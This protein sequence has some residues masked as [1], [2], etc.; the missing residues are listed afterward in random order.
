MP[1]DEDSVLIEKRYLARG[2]GMLLVG[3]TGIGKSSLACQIAY[4]F[5]LGIPC[6]GLQPKVEMRTL[7]MQAEND[8][9]DFVEMREGVPAR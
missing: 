4:S 8:D 6:F 2:G 3:P 7:I 9:G 1:D 5:A